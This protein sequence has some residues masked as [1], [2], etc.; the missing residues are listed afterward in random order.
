MPGLLLLLAAVAYLVAAVAYF[1]GLFR[2]SGAI[3]VL[4]WAL[5]AVVVAGETTL[6]PALLIL[7]VFGLFPAA[8]LLTH[9]IDLRKGLFI[10]P[11]IYSI[12]VAFAAGIVLWLA[13]LAAT[14]L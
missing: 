14:I 10:F 9:V 7:L 3:G 6:F 4:F 11:T 8:F 1:R 13:A 12:P 5:A 2:L